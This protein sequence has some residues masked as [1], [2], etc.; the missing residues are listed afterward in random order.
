[1][2]IAL[3]R[4]ALVAVSGL[5]ALL[6]LEGTLRLSGIAGGQD[7]LSFYEFDQELGWVTK[8]SEKE[9]LLAIGRR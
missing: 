1:M 9:V 3:I 5:V 8:K 6:I 7:R 4:L 2:K